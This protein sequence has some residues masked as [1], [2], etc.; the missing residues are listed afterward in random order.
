MQG[1]KAGGWGS[2]VRGGG[3]VGRGDGCDVVM[4]KSAPGLVLHLVILVVS[5]H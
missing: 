1:V 3:G 2:G 5:L 4:K